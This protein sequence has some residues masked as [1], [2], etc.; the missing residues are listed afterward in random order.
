MT[1]ADVE[2]QLVQ[3]SD[4]EAEYGIWAPPNPE[5]LWTAENAITDLQKGE[6]APEQL[7][8]RA[9]HKSEACWKKDKTAILSVNEPKSQLPSILDVLSRSIGEAPAVTEARPLNMLHTVIHFRKPNR[10]I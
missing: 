7:A 9:C 3:G 1:K 5:E 4:D 6:L 2:A 8:K 10:E